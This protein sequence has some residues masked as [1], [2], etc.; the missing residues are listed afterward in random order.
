L[1]GADRAAVSPARVASWHPLSTAVTAR[2]NLA[3]PLRNAKAEGSTPFV[4]TKHKLR[5]Q[6]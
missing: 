5:W 3:I 6:R 2:S 4:S 1:P